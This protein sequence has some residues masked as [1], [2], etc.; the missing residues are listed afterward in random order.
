MS[1]LPSVNGTAN[2]N[3]EK[4]S[5]PLRTYLKIGPFV[6]L[7]RF[8]SFLLGTTEVMIMVEVEVEDSY[9]SIL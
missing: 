6:V 7:S 8:A 9:Y 5:I 1:A 3:L 2:Q 4:T